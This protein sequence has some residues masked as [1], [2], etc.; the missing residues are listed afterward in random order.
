[1]PRPRIYLAGPEVF[2]PDAAEVGR[3]KQS[4][5]DAYGFEGVYPID[6]EAGPMT[7]TQREIAMAIGRKDHDMVR[8][9][10]VVVANVTPFRGPSAD[11]GTVYEM[12][13]AA[14]LGKLVCAYTNVARDFQGRTVEF[15]GPHNITT[16]PDGLPRDVDHLLVENWGLADNLMIE[17]GVEISG[18]CFVVHAAPPGELYTCLDGFETCLKTLRDRGLLRR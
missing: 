7:G 18:G 15:L 6:P 1:M 11:V 16:G 17:S 3:R 12:G 4:L 2:L 10:D 8:A 9:A 13:L 5:C 14:G